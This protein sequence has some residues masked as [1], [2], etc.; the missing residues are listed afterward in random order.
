MS[1]LFRPSSVARATATKSAPAT[2]SD[3]LDVASTTSAAISTAPADSISLIST[4]SSVNKALDSGNSAAADPQSDSVHTYTH[5]IASSSLG[6]HDDTV[7]TA[8]LV[9]TSLHSASEYDTE[10]AAALAD[11]MGMERR[12]PNG[13]PNCFFV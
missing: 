10:T 5:S 2:A 4:A 1:K 3:K 11:A 13:K 9:D 7:S 6:L 12:V 8:L